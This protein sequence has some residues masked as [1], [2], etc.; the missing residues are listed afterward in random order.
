MVMLSVHYPEPRRA[1]NRSFTLICRKNNPGLTIP[2]GDLY[3][4]QHAWQRQY[5]TQDEEI[6]PAQV[7]YDIADRGID[8][9]TRNRRQTG[10]QRIL[11]SCVARVRFA[12]DVSDESSRAQ[13]HAE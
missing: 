10:E 1:W 11:G 7:R 12:H 2:W 3:Q 13:P 9:S 4:H 6:E 8:E 5:K